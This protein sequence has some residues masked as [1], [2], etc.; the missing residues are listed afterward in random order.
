MSLLRMELFPLFESNTRFI[1]FTINTA[2][3]HIESAVLSDVR[4]AEQRCFGASQQW[5][6]STID[7]ADNEFYCWQPR[8]RLETMLDC[9]FM[10]SGRGVC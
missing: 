5:N 6:V 7:K 3:I 9:M 8:A 1:R 2:F 10:L 4:T